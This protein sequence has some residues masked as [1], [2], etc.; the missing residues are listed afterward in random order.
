MGELPITP[1]QTSA[2]MSK[3]VMKFASSF[4]T[5]SFNLESVFIAVGDNQVVTLSSIMDFLER[6]LN[7]VISREG[8]GGF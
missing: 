1:T 7:G 2:V 3:E 4:L 6:R 8:N 5:L